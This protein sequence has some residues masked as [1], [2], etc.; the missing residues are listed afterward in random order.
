MIHGTD[1]GAP[2]IPKLKTKLIWTTVAATAIFATC[3]EVYVNR[4]V[5][6]DGLAALIGL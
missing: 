1:P 2:A 4:L 6:L 3:Y 5:T